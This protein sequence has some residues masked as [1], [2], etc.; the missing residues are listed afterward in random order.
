MI[1]EIL[2]KLILNH[3][4]VK[5]HSERYTETISIQCL[6]LGVGDNFNLEALL[7]VRQEKSALLAQE[8]KNDPHSFTGQTE[9]D[10]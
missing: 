9:E 3:V 4:G 5:Q 2:G 1:S 7:E 8:I 6:T 10:C